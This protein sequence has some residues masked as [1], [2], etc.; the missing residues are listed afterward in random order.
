MTQKEFQNRYTYNTITDKLGEGG[1]G[2]IFKAYDNYR[3]RWVA[4]KISKVNPQFESVRLRKEVE[5]VA[6]L[7]VHPNIAYYED[8]FSYPSFDGDYDFGILQYYEEG[9]LNKLLKNNV[10]SYRQKQSIL[11]QILEGLDFLH[12]NGI[13]HR[14]LKPQNILIAK[15]GNEFIPKITDFGISKQL[16]INKSSVFNNSLAGAGTLAYASPEQLRESEI[17]KNTDL[18][19][20]GVIIF[21]IFTGQLPFTTG[22]HA[23]TSEAGRM[24]LFRQINSGRLPGNINQ[25]AEPWQT[26]IRRCL[27][28]NAA[29]RIKNTQ[30][31]KAILTHIEKSEDQSAPITPPQ[32]KVEIISV[33]TSIDKQHESPV[34]KPPVLTK[35]WL[36]IAC[37]AAIMAFVV[38]IYFSSGKRSAENSIHNMLDSTMVTKSDTV[39]EE[40]ERQEREAK[41][42]EEQQRIENE[43]LR[44]QQE[45]V[46]Q[47]KRDAEKQRKEKEEQNRR[48]AANLVQ[49]ASETFKNRSLGSSRYKQSFE[50]YKQAKDLGGDVSGGYR[51]F[52]SLVQSLIENGSGFDNQVKQMLQYAQQLNNTQEI[53]D[54]LEKCK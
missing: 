41:Q 51:N 47:E 6:K 11:M 49:Q 31:L 34:S 12:Q 54:L 45:K 27:I 48:D 42:R 36:L 28:T 8:C 2:T 10:L 7:P 37:I 38:I 5:T 20:F 24:E 4:L 17:R 21:Q 39:K 13:I 16:D 35:K 26:V 25:I 44:I 23:S 22:E 50:L 40:K 14:D 33:E 29:T 18:W 19:S 9:N 43:R 32:D 15:R 52:L 1:F 53:R 3:D 30:E 46:E